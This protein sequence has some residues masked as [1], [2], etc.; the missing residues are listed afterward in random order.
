MGA[1]EIRSGAATSRVLT[2]RSWLQRMHPVEKPKLL[3]KKEEVCDP[4]GMERCS[5]GY[6]KRGTST[7]KQQRGRDLFYISIGRW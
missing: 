4:L 2:N 1:R 6:L 5:T 3:S 7:R